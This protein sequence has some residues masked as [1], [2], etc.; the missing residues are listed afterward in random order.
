MIVVYTIGERAAN[1]VRGR[2]LLEV[3]SDPARLVPAV[4]ATPTRI[5]RFEAVGGDA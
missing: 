1:L 5:D 2:R 3:R 4:Y